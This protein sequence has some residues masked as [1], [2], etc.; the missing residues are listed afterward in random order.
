MYPK[1]ANYYKKISNIF[2]VTWGN[3]VGCC[4]R[5]VKLLSSITVCNGLLSEESAR[6]DLR[7]GSHNWTQSTPQAS[8]QSPFPTNHN[9]VEATKYDI[10]DKYNNGN[11][12]P[13]V[14][15]HQRFMNLII[16]IS[17]FWLEERIS[18]TR[19]HPFLTYSHVIIH[20]WAFYFLTSHWPYHP[21]DY[22][23]IRFGICYMSN[24]IGRHIYID[25]MI[26]WLHWLYDYT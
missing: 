15:I 25:L 9:H 18:W 19:L 7:E 13:E 21:C 11:N 12:M 14:A 17:I 16:D 3:S 5:S 23:H 22:V 1:I 8:H 2:G 26:C 4:F 20:V 6:S 24:H 10:N